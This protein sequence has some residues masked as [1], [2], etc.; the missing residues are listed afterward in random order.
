[1]RP[2]NT[3]PTPDVAYGY[4]WSDEENRRSPFR[5]STLGTLLNNGVARTIYVI[6]F[7]GYVL[8]YSDFFNSIFSFSILHSWGF[9]TFFQRLSMIYFGSC[10]LLLAYLLYL[11]FSP[12]LLRGKATPQDF[13]SAIC[14]AHDFITMRYVMR[15]T[16]RFLNRIPK[17]VSEYSKDRLD[18]FSAELFATLTSKQRYDKEFQNPFP[19]ILHFYYNYQNRERPFWR[20]TIFACAFALYI[21]LILPAIDLFVRVVG[22]SVHHL[23]GYF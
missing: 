7:A 9:L 21:L 10:L 3:A 13:V 12:T 1:M 15:D 2:Q 16:S 5:W 14:G 6:P 22:T 11:L 23:T 18:E 4:F 17:Q 8:L 19:S 20:A